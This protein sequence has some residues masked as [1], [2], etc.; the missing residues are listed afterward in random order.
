MKTEITNITMPRIGRHECLLVPRKDKSLYIDACSKSNKHYIE[1]AF[2]DTDGETLTYR[3]FDAYMGAWFSQIWRQ[4]KGA[5]GGMTATE[6]LE[7][8]TK[9]EIGIWVDVSEEFSYPQ[10][11]FQEQKQ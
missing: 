8:L 4:T 7:Y 10:L 6:V 5:T 9:H 1:L 2:I 11:A 3:L